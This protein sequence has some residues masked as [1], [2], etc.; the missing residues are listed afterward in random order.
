MKTVNI[1]DDLHTKAKIEAIRQ[2]MNLNEYIE[3]LVKKDLGIE[4]DK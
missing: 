1:N 2:G 3:S 4:K